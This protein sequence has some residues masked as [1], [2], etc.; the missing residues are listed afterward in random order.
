MNILD[1]FRRKTVARYD[2]VTQT[3]VYTDSMY[4]R[5]ALFVAPGVDHPDNPAWVKTRTNTDG[6]TVADIVQFT[7]RFIDGEARVSE[8]L[9]DYLVRN[10]HA[11]RSPVRQRPAPQ[12]GILPIA[13]SMPKY[14]TPISVGRPVEEFERLV[15]EGLA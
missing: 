3:S 15:R 7:I 1:L 8:A 2:N 13:E 5:G 9:A 14:K 6:G 12:P 4:G 11:K 10:R